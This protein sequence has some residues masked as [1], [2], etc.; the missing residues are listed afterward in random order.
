MD[1]G[2]DTAVFVSRTGKVVSRT[3]A[4]R[5]MPPRKSQHVDEDFGLLHLTPDDA[6]A[7]RVV[8]PLAAGSLQCQTARGH[9]QH[10]RADR[11]V[12]FARVLDVIAGEGLEGSV[13]PSPVVPKDGLRRPIRERHGEREWTPLGA[14]HAAERDERDRDAFH[15]ERPV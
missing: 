4:D 13:A 1:S 6:K 10:A 12:D 2:T 8:V 15:H 3:T 5:Q 9:E 11:P 7:G 14:S